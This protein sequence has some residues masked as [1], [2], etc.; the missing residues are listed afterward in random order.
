MR[1][2]IAVA[3]FAWAGQAAAAE[4]PPGAAAHQQDGWEW[5]AN[6]AARAAE[7][8]VL[9]AD[10]PQATPATGEIEVYYQI[11][12]EFEGEYLVAI[13]DRAGHRTT[14]MMLRPTFDFCVDPASLDD[15]DPGLFDVVVAKHGGVEF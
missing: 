2:L 6:N 13:T 11:G 4:C 5:I 10:M 3:L 9:D 7:D 15:E 8:Y 1:F 14:F 12:G